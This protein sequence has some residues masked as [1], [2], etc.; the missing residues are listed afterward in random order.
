[1]REAARSIVVALQKLDRPMVT[2]AVRYADT[3]AHGKAQSKLRLCC[4]LAGAE[5]LEV[6][7]LATKAVWRMMLGFNWPGVL[8]PNKVSENVSWHVGCASKH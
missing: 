5:A 6:L 4:L 1:M 8:G 7:N 2:W 3:T